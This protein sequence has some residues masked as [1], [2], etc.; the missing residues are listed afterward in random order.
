M[1]KIL[2]ELIANFIR[3]RGKT[4]SK[5]VLDMHSYG[6]LESECKKI[7]NIQTSLSI[8]HYQEIAIE[9]CFDHKTVIEIQ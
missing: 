6:L 5:I 1:I 4:P 9:I 7:S 2:D 8:T 3:Y